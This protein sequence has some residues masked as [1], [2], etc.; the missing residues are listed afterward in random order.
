MTGEEVK[1]LIKAKGFTYR[2]IADAIGETPMNLHQLLSSKDVRSGLL[3]RIASAMG[4]NAAYFYGKK[5][6]Y[7]LEEYVKVA[8]Q[9]QEIVYLRDLVTAKDELIESLREQIKTLKHGR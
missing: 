4:E 6:I 8:S 3:E 7:S 2:S 5:P 9:Q 1:K